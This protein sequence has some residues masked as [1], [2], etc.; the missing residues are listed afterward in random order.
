LEFEVTLRFVKGSICGCRSLGSSE[1]KD[2]SDATCAGREFR[3]PTS[4]AQPVKV[5]VLEKSN[6]IGEKSLRNCAILGY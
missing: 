4:R 2:T 5:K 3:D 1:Q 6:S